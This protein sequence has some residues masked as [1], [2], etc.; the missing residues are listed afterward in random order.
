MRSPWPL[1][2]CPRPLPKPSQLNYFSSS[3][4]WLGNERGRETKQINLPAGSRRDNS[5]VYS[6]EFLHGRVDTKSRSVRIKGLAP[7]LLAFPFPSSLSPCPPPLLS[8]SLLP[9][10]T[11][12]MKY[13]HPG[14]PPGS[15]LQGTQMRQC[16][17]ILI[18]TL[19]KMLKIQSQHL[20][21]CRTS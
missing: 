9:E 10:F 3:A 13:K 21:Q 6:T 5:G 1:L 20:K 14:L 18:A 15:V 2:C 11:Y 8:L 16:S 17:R 19:F 12:H 4:G 7:S